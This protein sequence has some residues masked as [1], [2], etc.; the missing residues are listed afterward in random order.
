MMTIDE[1]VTEITLSFG[2]TV[3]CEFGLI[4]GGEVHSVTQSCFSLIPVA[5]ISTTT[6]L[7]DL[8]ALCLRAKGSDL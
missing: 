3:L 4:F 7:S 2:D 8:L 6:L 5:L 1:V